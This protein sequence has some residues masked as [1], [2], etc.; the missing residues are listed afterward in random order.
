MRTASSWQPSVANGCGALQPIVA[1]RVHLSLHP[2]ATGRTT[3]RSNGHGNHDTRSVPELGYPID[4]WALSPGVML[5][6]QQVNWVTG[7]SISAL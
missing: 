2:V 1:D 4:V 3:R 5:H 6:E 7:L